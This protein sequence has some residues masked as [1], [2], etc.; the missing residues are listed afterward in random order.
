MNA[1]KTRHEHRDVAFLPAH[2]GQGIYIQDA[3][4]IDVCKSNMKWMNIVIMMKGIAG[5]RIIRT[6]IR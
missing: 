2:I 6:G 4:V 1:P 3:T 5:R